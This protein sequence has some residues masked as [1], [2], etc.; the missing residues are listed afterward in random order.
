MSDLQDP[1]EGN[2]LQEIVSMN[3]LV[4][5]RIY[6]ALLVLIMQSDKKSAEI[7]AEKHNRGEWIADY[8]WTIDN[9]V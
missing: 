6:D 8:P 2:E 4:N 1:S 9:S 7:L 3:L 5:M